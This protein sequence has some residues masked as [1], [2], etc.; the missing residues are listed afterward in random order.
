MEIGLMQ[1]GNPIESVSSK[2]IRIKSAHKNESRLLLGSNAVARNPE[3]TVGFV[4]NLT[5]LFAG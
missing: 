3:T 2:I 4:F 5:H 1:I